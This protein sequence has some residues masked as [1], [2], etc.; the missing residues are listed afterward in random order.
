MDRSASKSRDEAHDE[1]LRPSPIHS[2]VRTLSFESR[3]AAVEALLE[4][5]DGVEAFARAAF[6]ARA[7]AAARDAEGRARD[8]AERAAVLQ[9]W[10]RL[11]AAESRSQQLLEE[12]RA[13]SLDPP[14]S[15]AYVERADRL[16]EA[17]TCVEAARAREL[18]QEASALLQAGLTTAL[19]SVARE[20]LHLAHGEVLSAL[21]ARSG[22]HEADG[23]YERA[24]AEYERAPGLERAWQCWY[25][26]LRVHAR[27][28]EPARS[29]ALQ[30]RAL[31]VAWRGVQALSEQPKAACRLSVRRAQ[32]LLESARY[33][34]A[35][36]ADA[37]IEEALHE[38]ERAI[39][40]DPTAWQPYASTADAVR[41]Q[42]ALAPT[43]RARDLVDAALE[44]L[45]RGLSAIG[46]DDWGR[47]ELQ[48]QRGGLLLDRA[49][50]EAQTELERATRSCPQNE[51][52]WQSWARALGTRA[53]AAEPSDARELVT[54]ALD[55]L[56]RGSQYAR[57]DAAES[58]LAETRGELTL[59][60]A[61][62]E[63]GA[64]RAA[65]FEEAIAAFQRA[66]D[67]DATNLSAW[68]QWAGSLSARARRASMPE[69][70]DALWTRADGVLDRALQR[71]PLG[72]ASAA[73]LH[74]RGDLFLA[75][76]KG[77][78][79]VARRD[80]FEKAVAC[81]EEATQLAPSSGDAPWGWGRALAVRGLYDAG[82]PV[83]F[84]GWALERYAQAAAALDRDRRGA[85][86]CELASLLSPLARRDAVAAEPLVEAVLSELERAAA[87]HPRGSASYQLA[88]GALLRDAGREAAAEAAF[89]AGRSAG[90]PARSVL[91]CQHAL[92][93]MLEECASPR[94]RPEWRRT[95]RAFEDY[96]ETDPRATGDWGV[97]LYEVFG[98]TDEAEAKLREALEPRAEPTASVAIALAE[99]ERERAETDPTSHRE[100]VDRARAAERFVR[101][102]ALDPV[103]REVEL[104][105]LAMRLSEYERADRHFARA[106]E[107][108]GR[109][110]RALE[111]AGISLWKQGKPEAARRHFENAQSVAPRDRAV[112]AKLG[113]T[114]AACGDLMAAEARLR[115]LLESSP[116]DVDALR[117]LASVHLACAEA[118]RDP[119]VYTR[120]LEA[121]SAAISCARES[122][123]RRL[124][125][126]ELARIY[127]A[128]GYT[129]L[130]LGQLEPAFLAVDREALARADFRIAR[131][132]DPTFD[133]ARGALEK[134]RSTPRGSALPRLIAALV[135]VTALGLFG[136]AQLGF[137]VPANIGVR[138]LP[139]AGYLA[140][141]F[142]ALTFLAWG[143]YLPLRIRRGVPVELERCSIELRDS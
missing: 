24:Y 42:A 19:D 52:P 48:Q 97:L 109:N 11:A 67:L 41:A 34:S 32:A 94:A 80:A 124:R 38:L 65:R 113:A 66:V 2:D 143:A 106:L 9:L 3:R 63:P 138:A 118:S 73:L 28:V 132:L 20:Q 29:H 142:G 16:I 13:Q 95:E 116:N 70:A 121:A 79:G 114:L 131:K 89:E 115:T 86:W 110:L 100:F 99:L 111:G 8:G 112:S 137:W 37:R 98:P 126:R 56:A 69:Q 62:L 88:R 18:L 71:L 26:R 17:A 84:F 130:A 108:D 45:A 44:V 50:D 39:E 104:G 60:A 22:K 122:T 10:G 77:A 139:L 47:S 93:A 30:V 119:A 25:E 35:D 128:R 127:Y 6:F 101:S 96:A 51:K 12:T 15:L 136:L 1:A 141:T 14:A 33:G 123:G 7:N 46:G 64:G 58:A 53:R 36:S 55:V 4:E 72:E 40:L 43:D 129:G 54:R 57:D 125:A 133:A 27:G 59:L 135:C 61:E 49:F 83:A 107:L 91:A 120:A 85:A 92:S 75:Q 82:D 134:L 68:R 23:L 105:L 102:L 76:A 87:D 21:A 103:D 140:L 31:E 5:A 74:D 78:T 81:F 117:G 90:A